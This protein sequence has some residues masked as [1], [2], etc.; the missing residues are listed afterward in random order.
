MAVKIEQIKIGAVF[1][2]K[3]GPRRVTGF[4][5]QMGTGFNVKWEYADGRKRGGRLT[6]SM[7][8]HYFR[9]KAIEE[10][11]DP[12][13]DGDVL[14]LLSGRE[15]AIYEDLVTITIS[16]H[17]PAKWALVDLEIGELWGHDGTRLR[18][19]SPAEAA[20]VE[21]VAKQAA[22]ARELNKRGS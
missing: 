9:A 19:L 16:T 5:K 22:K 8:V 11:P 21:A 7:W 3:N 14:R 2:F 13:V 6:G 17:C 4:G 10:I 15:A 1:L 20:E 12:A 18:Y